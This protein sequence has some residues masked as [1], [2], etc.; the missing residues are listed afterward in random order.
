[1]RPRVCRVDAEGVVVSKSND[2]LA[3]MAAMASLRD[4]VD[5]YPMDREDIELIK[6]VGDYLHKSHD[7]AVEACAEACRKTLIRKD[8]TDALATVILKL[9]LSE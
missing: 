8:I 7:A 2:R 1:V 3:A 6:V 5:G 9:K 4:I